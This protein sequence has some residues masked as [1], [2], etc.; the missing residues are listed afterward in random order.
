[1]SEN[2]TPMAPEPI[3]FADIG[4]CLIVVAWGLSLLSVTN[5]LKNEN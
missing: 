3:H 5:R 1:M 4:T 2:Q